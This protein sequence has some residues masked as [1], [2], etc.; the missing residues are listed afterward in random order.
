VFVTK[1]MI[2]NFIEKNKK[3]TKQKLLLQ[4]SCVYIYI[5]CMYDKLNYEIWVFIIK[6]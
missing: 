3:Q 4:T 1:H 2:R 5:Y 6:I